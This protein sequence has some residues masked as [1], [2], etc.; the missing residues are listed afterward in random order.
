LVPSSPRGW[1]FSNRGEHR[2]PGS[3]AAVL[4]QIAGFA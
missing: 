4:L 2:G 3:A 1:P